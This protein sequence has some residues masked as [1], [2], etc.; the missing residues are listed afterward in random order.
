MLNELILADGADVEA[1]RTL[2]A[3]INEKIVFSARVTSGVTVTMCASPCF[4]TDP[5]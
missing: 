1:A 4:S 2:C 5:A 3:T